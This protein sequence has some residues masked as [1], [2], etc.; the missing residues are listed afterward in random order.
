M[1]SSLAF[2]TSSSP[3]SNIDRHAV[4]RQR[5][6]ERSGS[7]QYGWGWAKAIEIQ[8]NSRPLATN[9]I[10]S[11]C[12]TLTYLSVP[13][14]EQCTHGRGCLGGLCPEGRLRIVAPAPADQGRDG[15]GQIQQWLKQA[16]SS[17]W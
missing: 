16:V 10:T 6:R 8:T 2:G 14:D 1:A 3:R 5:P 7:G 12:F 17:S 4:I 11:P 9:R 13:V 15:K